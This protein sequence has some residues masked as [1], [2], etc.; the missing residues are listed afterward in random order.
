[1]NA[2]HPLNAQHL[3]GVVAAESARRADAW[4]PRPLGPSAGPSAVL[5]R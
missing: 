3:N 1:M 2:Q 5:P 4:K